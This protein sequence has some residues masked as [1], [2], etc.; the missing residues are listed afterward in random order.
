MGRVAHCPGCLITPHPTLF[1]A[2]EL[3]ER[4]RAPEKNFKSIT[5]PLWTENKA[6][7]IQ[8][9]IQLF[10][11]VTKHGAYIDGFAAPQ[12]R[13]HTELC[14]AKLVLEAQPMRVRDVWLCDIDP[15]GVALLEGIKAA[16]EVK[17]RRV[18]VVEGD[19]NLTIK[20]ILA[21]GRVTEKT[22]TFALLDQRTFECA[23]ST[24]ETLA[25]HKTTRKIELFYF[26]ATGWLD[27]ALTATKTPAGIAT[28]ER[29]W[30]RPDWQKLRGMQGL[31]RARLFVERFKQ[32][33]GYTYAY[34]F[35]IYD[36]KHRGRTMYH[37]IHATDHQDASPLMVR[38]YRKA[39]GRKDWGRP[40][41]QA[42]L[43]ELWG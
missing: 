21:S 32:E 36:A 23:W 35:A 4:L 24:V 5:C 12:R 25:R 10:T 39:S 13:N 1:D 31:D 9:Y 18:R 34:P 15:K 38:A 17:G 11:Y 16:H 26:V 28:I 3:P 2:A 27:R 33:L 29:W 22:A 30:G 8:G 37:M 43:A 20:D 41:S 6:K 14:S 7:L 40:I 42:D 19:F